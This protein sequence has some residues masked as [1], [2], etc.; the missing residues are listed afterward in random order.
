M[1][2]LKAPTAREEAE[3][4]EL[5]KRIKQIEKRL[6]EWEL[7]FFCVSLLVSGYFALSVLLPS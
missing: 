6:S 7:C 3:H 1:T 2:E 5:E 4:I